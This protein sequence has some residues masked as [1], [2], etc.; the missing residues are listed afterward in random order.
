MDPSTV[1]QLSFLAQSFGDVDDPVAS[2]HLQNG[3][4]RVIDELTN[5]WA[6]KS[7]SDGECCLVALGHAI[8]VERILVDAGDGFPSADGLDRIKDEVGRLSSIQAECANGNGDDVGAQTGIDMLHRACNMA[9]GG[10]VGASNP[11]IVRDA[12]SKAVR[13]VQDALATRGFDSLVS[14]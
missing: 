3:R 9:I 7:L 8:R 2:A 13:D 6:I 11:K 1:A 5:E 12:V 14:G 4:R 10:G